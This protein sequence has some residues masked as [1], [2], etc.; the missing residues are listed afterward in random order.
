MEL[1]RI[2]SNII[3]DRDKIKDLYTKNSI[4]IE[5][6]KYNMQKSIRSEKSAHKY[7]KV[8]YYS[9]DENE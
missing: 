2:L 9:K 1:E 7:K 8:L 3:K 5:N 4:I 6:I